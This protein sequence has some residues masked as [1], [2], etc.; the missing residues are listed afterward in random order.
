MVTSAIVRIISAGALAALGMLGVALLPLQ[1]AATAP[2]ATREAPKRVLILHDEDKDSFPGLAQIDRALRESFRDALGRGVE[3][4]SESLALSRLDRPGY[5]SLVAD[6][7]RRKYAVAMPDLIVAVMEPSLDFLLRHGSSLFPGIPIVFCGADAATMKGKVLPPNVTGVLVKRKFSSSL[8]VALR[9]QPETR[10]VFVMGGA[11]AFDRYL[12]AFARRDLQPF[13][14]RVSITYLFGLPMDEWLKRV[15]TLPANSVILFTTVFADGAGRRFVPHEA[16]SSIVAAANAPVYVSLDQ[17]VGLGPV[18]GNVYSFE[19]H[20][21]VVAELA[22]QIARG[23]PPASLPVREGGEQVDLFDARAL[24]RWNL[25]PARLPP[26]S[27]VRYQDPSVWAQYHWYII[28]VIAVLATQSALIGAL[29]IVRRRQRR[30]EAE[31]RR[32]RD[33]LA[34]VL[35]VTSLSELTSSLAHEISQ[36]II[37]ILLNAQAAI[38][39]RASG[40]AGSEND[41]EEALGD[42]V[43]SAQHASQVIQRLRALFRKEYIEPSVVDLKALIEDVVHVLHSAMLTER[44]DIR[45]AYAEPIPSVRGDPVQLKQVLLNVVRN[46]CDAIGAGGDGPRAIT[47]RVHQG[48]PGQVAIEIVDAG[49]GVVSSDLERIFDPFVSTKPNGL[50]MGLA[51][52]RSIIDGHGGRIWATANPDRG[53]K[54]HIELPCLSEVRKSALADHSS[55]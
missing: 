33:D 12:E 29:F 25:D 16:L 6:F 53:L 9:L 55:A 52:S 40:S 23:T 31:A 39:L 51:I 30:A 15:S 18:G 14:G 54:I 7:Y 26:G 21:A 28:A 44:I 2:D 20:G 43:R 19:R 8:D 22:L 47:I 3:V 17:F 10:N 4:Q 38:A 50:G 37:A 36:P 5:D 49:V 34:H 35:R 45:L 13:E 48:R 42:I 24:K 11:S 32:H 41:V 27:V 46:A 1:A